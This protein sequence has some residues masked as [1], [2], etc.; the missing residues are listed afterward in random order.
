MRLELGLELRLE[1]GLELG[2]G[3]TND[4]AGL[5]DSIAYEAKVR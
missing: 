2:L 1:L 3:L 5:T 4:W